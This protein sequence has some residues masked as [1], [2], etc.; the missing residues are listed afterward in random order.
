MDVARAEADLNAYLERRARSVP[1]DRPGQHAANELERLWVESD[2]RF[3]VRRRMRLSAE[4][5][6]YH[7]HLS[8]VFKRMGAEHEAKALAEL[9]IDLRKE[10]AS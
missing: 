5:Y 1:E 4:R 9:E 3:R 6:A 8:D 2:L 7:L 10:N